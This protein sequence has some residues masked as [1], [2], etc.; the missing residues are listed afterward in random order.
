MRETFREIGK[1]KTGLLPGKANELVS[2]SR[3]D[4]SN[5]YTSSSFTTKCCRRSSNSI[6]SS[7]SDRS[8]AWLAFIAFVSGGSVY[9]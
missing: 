3:T 8:R 9:H 5:Y 1:S 7:L 4:G 2:I 6:S